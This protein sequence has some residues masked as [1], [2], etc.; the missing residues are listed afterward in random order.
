MS[1]PIYSFGRMKI[2]DYDQYMEQYG[3]PFLDIL[4]QFKGKLLAATK[5]GHVIEGKED[6]NWT[7]LIEFPNGKAAAEFY[8]SPA[9]APLKKLRLETLTEQALAISFPAEIPS[10]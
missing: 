1:T 4:A 6:G 9:Y 8:Q 2:K 3:V 7:V 10:K 5:N